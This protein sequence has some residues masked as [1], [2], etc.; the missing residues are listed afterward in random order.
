LLSFLQTA[1]HI[2]RPGVYQTAMKEVDA[3]ELKPNHA[4]NDVAATEALTPEEDKRLLR[5]IDL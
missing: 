5:R 3:T 2:T 4:D 1:T